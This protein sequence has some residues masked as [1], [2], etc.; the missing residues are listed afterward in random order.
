M[1][2]LRKKRMENSAR[3]SSTKR[4]H[5]VRCQFRPTHPIAIL[6]HE[7]RHAAT[8]IPGAAVGPFIDLIQAALVASLALMLD[9]GI[10]PG[11]IANSSGVRAGFAQIWLDHFGA[12]QGLPMLNEDIERVLCAYAERFPSD[13][14]V[15]AELRALQRQ[16]ADIISRKEFRG[17]I[18]C[19]AI[20]IGEGSRL[21]MI[22]HRA[23]NRWLF[24][25]GH[26]ESDDRSLRAAAL[27]EI[28]EET[29]VPAS[30]L[31][32]PSDAFAALPIQIDCHVIPANTAKGEPEHRHF[33]FRFVFKG[34]IDQFAVQFE[35]VND[36]AWMA[37][38]GA[39]PPIQARLRELRLI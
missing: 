16:K 7:P 20:V 1:P 33:D 11:I 30:A 34:L 12:D 29:G 31:S 22:H 27:R 28:A 9:G 39:A 19:G 4:A 24:P 14:D 13:S 15:I 8:F 35:E 32:A 2:S 17:H 5:R 18:T 10:L 36:C 6:S 38:N 26:L 37:V 25:G 21:L 3:M 23:L